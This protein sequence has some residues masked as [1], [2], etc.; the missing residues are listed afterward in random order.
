[1]KVILRRLVM[2]IF[3]ALLICA[4]TP[5]AVSAADAEIG[6]SAKSISKSKIAENLVLQKDGTYTTDITLSLPSA[7]ETL[8][9][10]IV[11][12]V[13]VSSFSAPHIAFEKILEFM[14]ATVDDPRLTADSLKY[15]IVVY[16]GSAVTFLELQAVNSGTVEELSKKIDTLYTPEDFDLSSEKDTWKDYF[17]E[18]KAIAEGCNFHAGLQAAY[19]ILKKDKDVPDNRKYVYSVMDSIGS[20]FNNAAGETQMIYA[21]DKEYGFDASNLLW[22]D[23]Y[24]VD[25][26]YGNYFFDPDYFDWDEYYS[27]VVEYVKNDKGKY[28]VNYSAMKTALNAESILTLRSEEFPK[29]TVPYID[30]EESA[31]KKEYPALGVDRAVYECMT[32]TEK[33]T[34]EGI[35][36]YAALDYPAYYVDEYF[37]STFAGELNKVAGKPVSVMLE[38][39]YYDVFY[40]VAEG[41]R[42]DDYMGYVEGSYNFDFVNDP[43]KLILTVGKET[44]DPVKID[45]NTYGFGPITVKTENGT[46]ESYR[47][48]LQ[49]SPRDKD[50]ECFYL[51]INEAVCS[52]VPVQLTYT[53]VLTNPETEDG[54]YGKYDADGSKGYEGLCANNKALLLPML[55]SYDAHSRAPS[56][57]DDDEEIPE[58]KPF[59]LTDPCLDRYSGDEIYFGVPTISYT[60]GKV[61]P[62]LDGDNHFA[63]I[64]G[65]PDQMIRPNGTITRAEVATI[66]FRLLK[67]DIRT[68][69]MAKVNNFTDV[70]ADKWYNIAISTLTKLGVLAGYPDGTFGPNDTITRA[71][72]TAIAA[73][74]DQYKAKADADFTDIEGHWAKVYIAIAADKG[75]VG[76]YPDGTFKP[77]QKISRAETVALVNRVLDRNI[78]KEKD[79]VF[80]KGMISWKDNQDTTKWYYYDIQE[81]TN[82]HDY[83]RYEKDG[84]NYE[85]WTAVK[86]NP[87][88]AAL[89]K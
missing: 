56:V 78:E 73:R 36:C 25:T 66:F 11:F 50:G 59:S 40:L 75:W 80:C 21:E 85:I 20:L 35:H 18:K 13:D 71:E 72:F 65:Y 30:I 82:S 3:A 53:E 42:I 27:E 87:D 45:K 24:G 12:V 1:M 38:S 81:A 23:L 43:S 57:S 33:M 19:D 22:G 41:S 89:E 17:N 58:E 64:I 8:K 76:G 26:P 28:D 37:T 47:Y 67:D 7:K 48:L 84:I 44:L 55:F 16:R 29:D 61:P 62:I 52:F 14:T 49:Y 54:V 4:T 32:L 34:K 51:T 6:G 39:L 69:N 83:E 70:D 5:L 79:D 15:S 60:V 88:W 9:S 63:Y 86:D 68:A 2:L 74:F 77:D 10:D 31:R 46:E